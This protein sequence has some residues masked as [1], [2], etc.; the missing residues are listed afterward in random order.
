MT[1]EVK[2]QANRPAITTN[3]ILIFEEYP[4]KEFILN[5]NDYIHYKGCNP[6]E[7][8]CGISLEVANNCY[9]ELERNNYL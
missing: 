5:C 7:C 3:D 4:N 8:D 6:N 9:K 1:H 2:Y